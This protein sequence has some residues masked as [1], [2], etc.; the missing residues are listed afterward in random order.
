MSNIPFQ[1]DII[2]TWGLWQD[3]DNK[4]SVRVPAKTLGNLYNYLERLA[5]E[6]SHWPIT[7]IRVLADGEEIL[8]G[9][10]TYED[11]TKSVWGY[12]LTLIDGKT[13]LLERIVI[14]QD[15]T[16]L[17][18]DV[19]D[20]EDLY[21]LKITRKNTRLEI[22]SPTFSHQPLLM[23]GSREWLHEPARYSMELF[24]GD[25]FLRIKPV[26]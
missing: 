24:A 7:D 19:R 12:M 14:K 10:P 3:T 21:F 2:L 8:T 9:T 15:L 25:E 26:I 1:K 22:T 13:L 11:E 5:Y 17:E 6:L 20:F 23:T 16:T 18:A 4:I